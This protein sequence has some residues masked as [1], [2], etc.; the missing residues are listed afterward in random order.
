MFAAVSEAQ[1]ADKL[2]VRELLCVQ[3]A[4]VMNTSIIINLLL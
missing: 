3:G 4:S 2:Q 1:P